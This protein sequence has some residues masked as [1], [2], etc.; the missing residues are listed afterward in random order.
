[1]D[2]VAAALQH[3]TAE[4]VVEDHSGR[5]AP[6]LESADMPTQEVLHG[7]I[8]EEFEIQSPRIR[9]RHH[10]AGQRT[11]GATHGD[12]AE[13]GPVHLGLLGG[14]GVQTQ[15]CFPNGRTQSGYGAP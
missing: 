1:M 11:L 9:E 6:V 13:M 14:E 12:V 8:E 4:I 15:E 2:L 10:E 3:G 7:L 5:A